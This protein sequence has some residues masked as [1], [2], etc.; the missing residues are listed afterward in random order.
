MYVC[1]LCVYFMCVFYLC[2][3]VYILCVYLCVYFM[4]VFYVCIYVCIYVYILCVYCTCALYVC[5][6]SVYLC[7]LVGPVMYIRSMEGPIF[8]QCIKTAGNDGEWDSN[9]RAQAVSRF[10]SCALKHS[11]TVPA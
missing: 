10:E 8:D 6:L 7:V 4:C 3:Y 5:I 2:I 1:I 11:A 9:P